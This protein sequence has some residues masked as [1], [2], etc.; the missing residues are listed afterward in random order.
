M[1][2]GFTF[3]DTSAIFSFYIIGIYN[4]TN[5]DSKIIVTGKLYNG[6]TM[7]AMQTFSYAS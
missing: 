7:L 3:I 5:P 1:I 2:T 4:P 6:I